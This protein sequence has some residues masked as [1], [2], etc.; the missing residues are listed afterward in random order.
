MAKRKTK[1]ANK[2]KKRKAVKVINK[3]KNVCEFC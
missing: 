1:K 2:S 3:K